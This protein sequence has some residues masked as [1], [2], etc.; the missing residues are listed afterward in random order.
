M[1][2]RRSEGKLELGGFGHRMPG[3][4]RARFVSDRIRRP[5]LPPSP[6]IR[7]KSAVSGVAKHHHRTGREQ[8][9]RKAR[10]GGQ[11]QTHLCRVEIRIADVN[12]VIGPCGTERK[13]ISGELKVPAP[14]YVRSDNRSEFI[15]R[16]RED[17]WP[18]NIR[19][20]VP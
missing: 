19:H 13:N 11:S 9:V 15:A 7:I 8:L 6:I 14:E 12:A 16:V 5:N 18:K 20:T 3:A 17:G 2:G 1:P 4:S 10:G